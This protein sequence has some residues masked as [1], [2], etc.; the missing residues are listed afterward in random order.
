MLMA[1]PAVG[2]TT[3]ANVDSSNPGSL[4]DLLGDFVGCI[5]GSEARELV[6]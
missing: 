4:Y 5:D 3:A 1:L 2:P 6:P